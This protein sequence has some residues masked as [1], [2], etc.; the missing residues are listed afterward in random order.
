ME[1]MTRDDM[2]RE[3][4]KH[5]RRVGNLMLDVIERLSRRAMQHDDSKFSEVEF[6]AFAAET[7]GL[8]ELTYGSDEYKAAIKRLGPALDHHQFCNSHHPEYYA[9]DSIGQPP[10][11]DECVKN[12]TAFGKMDLL[13]LIEMLADWKA[14]TERHADGD[15]RRSIQQN[16]ARFGYGDGTVQLLMQTAERLGWLLPAQGP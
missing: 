13:D 7:P 4:V 3:T 1:K 5:V 12:G 9:W 16:A 6:P 2:M 10:D 11:F 14:A 8:K 15:L